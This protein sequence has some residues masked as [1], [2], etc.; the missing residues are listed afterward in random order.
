MRRLRNPYQSALKL[1]KSESSRT[2]SE[3]HEDPSKKVEELPRKKTGQPLLIR[4]ELDTQVQEYV[5]H[6]RKRGLAINTSI[7]IAA[8][9]GIVINQDANQ[10]SDA[11]GGIN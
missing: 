10:L 5:R 7:V 1:R 9:R 6:I 3:D 11:G 4:D 2:S 8:G